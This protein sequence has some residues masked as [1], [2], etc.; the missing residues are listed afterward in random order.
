MKKGAS[1]QEAHIANRTKWEIISILAAKLQEM[2]EL[3]NEVATSMA[4]D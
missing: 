2:E 3:R 4:Q 1:M